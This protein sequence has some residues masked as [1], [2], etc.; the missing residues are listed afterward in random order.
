MIDNQTRRRTRQPS[1]EVAPTFSDISPATVNFNLHLHLRTWPT[2]CQCEPACQVY[3]S[4]IIRFQSYCR[5][6][7]IRTH[8]GPIA[9]PGP[10]IT[11][12]EIKP[13]RS[14]VDFEGQHEAT[15]PL[16]NLS[17]FSHWSVLR[18]SIKLH[19]LASRT[20]SYL[21]WLL[22]DYIKIFGNRYGK[23]ELPIE[24]NVQSSVNC[25]MVD[26]QLQCDSV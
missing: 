9:L 20:P 7:L 13:R 17:S 26:T 5:D 6:T 16:G 3:R 25:L 22:W 12:V 23:T 4:E 21:G 2:W 14:A 10:Q 18:L 11:S 15:C 1:L 19:C 8:I 24:A